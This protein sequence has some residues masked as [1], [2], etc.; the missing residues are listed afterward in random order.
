L[1]FPRKDFNR[2]TKRASFVRVS[3]HSQ[4]RTIRQPARRKARPAT[5]SRGTALRGFTWFTTQSRFLFPASFF[6][7]KALLFAGLVACFG[8]QAEAMAGREA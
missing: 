4:I 1:F 7:Q 2:C 8:G 5:W 6:F 3:S